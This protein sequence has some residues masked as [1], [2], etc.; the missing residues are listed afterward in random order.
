MRG[1]RIVHGDMELLEKLGF[2]P[3]LL[4]VGLLPHALPELTALFLPLAA[5]T[6][7]S[8]SG[9]WKDLLAATLVTTG[10]AVPVL[11]ATA[12]IETQVTP[13]LLLTL[14]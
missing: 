8:R 1:E 12:F 11:V 5:W 14:R 13:H 9:A 10:L 2:S 4:I 7:A 6:I 3:E